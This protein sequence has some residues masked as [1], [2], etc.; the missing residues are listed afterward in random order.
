VGI[1]LAS[2]VDIGIGLFFLPASVLLFVPAFNLFREELG[3]IG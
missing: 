1:L 2:F 3:N